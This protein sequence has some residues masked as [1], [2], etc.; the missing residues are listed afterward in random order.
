[1]N[2]IR[3]TA[4][5]AGAA[6]LALV[7]ALCPAL[8]LTPQQAYELL[9]LYY[10]DELP[11]GLESYT[12]VE[13]MAAALGDPYTTYMTAEEYEAFVSST[14]D[15]SVVGIGVTCQ[16]T[17]EGLLISSVLDDSPAQE[18]GL[19]PGD[20]IIAADG[21]SLA[22]MGDAATTLVRGEAGTQ[23]TLTVL[24]A[25]GT[26]GVFTLIRREVPIPNTTVELLPTGQGYILCDSFGDDTTVHF[27]EGITE[28][29]GQAESWVVDLRANPGGT[30]QASATASAYFTGPGV[31]VY[32]RD[33]AGNVNYTFAPGGFQRLTEKQALVLTSPYSAS[34]SELFAAT[35]RDYG[36]GTLMGS[37]T[38]GKGVAQMLLT[39]E[40]Y[41]D[42]FP[43]GDALK[44][45][46][47]RFYSPDGTTNDKLGVIPHILVS[48]AAAADLATLLHAAVPADSGDW[49]AF[50][51]DG[52]TW[53]VDL[54]E[55][56]SADHRAALTEL[57][58]ALPPVAAVEYGQGGTGWEAS[59]PGYVAQRWG[60][61]LADRGFTDTADSDYALAIGTLATYELLAGDGDG[62]FR[63]GDTLTRGELACLLSSMLR[64][65]AVGTDHFSDVEGGDW[66]AGGVN[67]ICE[68]GFIAGYEDGT[69]RPDEPI[70]REELIAI[71]AQV[72]AWLNMDLGSYAAGY[73]PP[74]GESY[75][76][77]S[78]WAKPAVSLC[79]AFG[80][81]WTD[82]GSIDAGAPALREETAALIYQLLAVT[83]VLPQ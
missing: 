63:P 22:G 56:S 32:F 72:G 74:E 47:Y 44:V 77:F 67:A 33:G 57:L 37:R 23:V 9:E 51:I 73:E 21:Q 43:D 68:A 14:N 54:A 11:E 15:G 50:T 53:Y 4:L 26:T 60:L 66:Y 52:L 28:Y 38:F 71:L 24:R 1:M 55:A 64:L 16:I 20:L 70:T 83:G 10:V 29:D 40:L 65:D 36:V 35:L 62:A 42:C 82:S 30:A 75:P 76:N 31:L 3:K 39:D 2:T 46:T 69:F 49:M 59:D 17:A 41:P 25:D 12:D 13:E 7:L 34:G 79:D 45:T 61:T 81:L 27:T 6:A 78:D 8:A 58:E 18:L 19:V 80:L 48:D 5:R